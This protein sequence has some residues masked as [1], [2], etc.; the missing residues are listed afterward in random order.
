[1]RLPQV[2]LHLVASLLALSSFLPHLTLAFTSYPDDFVN[3]NY[4]LARRYPGNTGGAQ[5]SILKWADFLAPQGPWTVIDKP[6]AP[7]S[8]DMHDYMSW[9]PY[10]WPNC[11]AL[12]NTTE[13]PLPEVWSECPYYLRDGLF[14]PRRHF[15]AM[16]DAVWMNSLAWAMTGINRYAQNAATFLNVWFLQN[17]TAMNPN[18]I[19]SQMRRGPGKG[20]LGAHTGE[21]DLKCM[22]KIANAILIL[23][24]GKSFYWTNDLDQ[25]MINWCQRFVRWFTTYWIALEEAAAPKS[26]ATFVNHG[27]YYY[28]QLA[29]HYLIVNDI[30]SA[31]QAIKTYFTTTYMAQITADGE[32]P[33]EARRT[34]PYHYRAYNLIAMIT[35]AR[36]GE[37]L[38]LD[39]WNWTGNE[40]AGIKAALDYAMTIPPRTENADE[41]YQ[42]IAAVAAKF[43]DPDGKYA[44][45]LANADPH[46]PSAPYF[47]WS[48][49]FS[50]S[51]LP[52]ARPGWSPKR[53]SSAGKSILGGP[54]TLFAVLPA[55]LGFIAW[56]R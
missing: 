8:G 22:A 31:R 44:N 36:I 24:N 54:T 26:V 30:E 14:Q 18:L 10:S 16:A 39:Y 47:L 52:A 34:R 49:P 15:N 38:G 1:M 20:Q 55:V 45:F 3:P 32:Q 51:G 50:D 6:V 4:V 23:R 28:A 11:S 13:L 37:Y 42:P 17:S 29:S 7:P 33:L 5:F 9:S 46:Y 27:S 43:G 12:G 2:A 35:N 41:L 25:G 21:L 19:Y 48:Q 56:R 40:G 53:D